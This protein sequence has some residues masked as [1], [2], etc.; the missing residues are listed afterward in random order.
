[1]DVSA[2]AL[3]SAQIKKYMCI[4]DDKYLQPGIDVFAY[5]LIT[6]TIGEDEPI[7][8]HIL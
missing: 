6:P 3:S 1:M 5:V 2:Y 8:T 7:L 4:I